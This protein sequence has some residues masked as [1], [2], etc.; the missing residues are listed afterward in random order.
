MPFCSCDYYLYSDTFYESSLLPPLEA[1]RI[2]FSSQ[3]FQISQQHALVSVCFHP[4]LMD[5]SIWKLI[6]INSRKFYDIYLKLFSPLSFC[7]DY[8]LDIVSFGLI[9]YNSI[10]SRFF[11]YLLFLSN[12]WN[13]PLTLF[14]NIFTFFISVICLCFKSSVSLCIFCNKQYSFPPAYEYDILC[15]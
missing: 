5:P 15:C 7:N 3:C 12:F 2:A 6:P 1:C 14:S 8:S 9:L 10:Y 11:I 4:W 13:C